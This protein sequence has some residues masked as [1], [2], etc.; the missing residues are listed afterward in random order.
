MTFYDVTVT[1]YNLAGSGTGMDT[2]MDAMKAFEASIK[3]GNWKN[4]EDCGECERNGEYTGGPNVLWHDFKVKAEVI[5][6]IEKC[7]NFKWNE[8]YKLGKDSPHEF[9]EKKAAASADLWFT[10]EFS[11]L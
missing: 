1:S 3:P 6:E 2:L 7:G 8:T 11:E 9:L 4:V 5:L 10:V